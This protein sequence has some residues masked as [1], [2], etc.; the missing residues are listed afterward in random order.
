LKIPFISVIYCGVMELDDRPQEVVEVT[1]ILN[2]VSPLRA[3]IK[4]TFIAGRYY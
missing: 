1:Y 4:Q 2:N 3:D